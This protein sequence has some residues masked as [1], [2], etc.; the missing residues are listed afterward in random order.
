MQ[1]QHQPL[2]PASIALRSWGANIA[3]L[4]HQADHTQETFGLLFDPPIHQSTVARWESGAIEP[5]L[6][7]K[8]E[9]AAHLGQPASAIFPLPTIIGAVA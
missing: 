1:K 4:R 2:T 8:L 7:R 5:A 3:R 9:I 6:G